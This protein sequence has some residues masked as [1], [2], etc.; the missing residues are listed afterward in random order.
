V[1]QTL[2][3]DP[4]PVWI[5]RAAFAVLFASAAWQKL[6]DRRAFA[7]VLVAYRVLPEG[8]VAPAAIAITGVEVVLAL[9]WLAPGGPSLA[10][11]ATVAVLL[12]YALAIALN[13]VRGRRTIDCGC[14]VAGT[15][16]PIG[17]WLLVRNGLLALMALATL[18]PIAA[19]P[20]VWVD[21]VTCAAGLAVVSCVWLA[22][23]GLA[24]ARAR[25]PAAVRGVR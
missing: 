21:G 18:Q 23:H 5:L 15:R 16:Q 9:A 3:H 13:L 2:L 19:R 8:L 20:L 14:G 22:G 17:E 12:V 10:A 25:V 11:P 6:R 7:A 24:A 4:V 1:T